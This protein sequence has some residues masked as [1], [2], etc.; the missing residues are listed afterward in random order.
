MI[1]LKSL[2]LKNLLSHKDTTIEFD[3]TFKISLEGASGNGKS[4]IV[5][6]IVWALYGSG[7]ADNRSI[8]RYSEKSASVV[9]FLTKDDVLY[10]IERSINLKGKHELKVFS[11]I[12][13]DH[14]KPI[15]TNGVRE[16]QDHLENEIL[17]SSYELFVN[18]IVYPQDAVDSFI[19]QTAAKRKDILLEIA[20]ASS[21][22]EYYKKTS[23]VISEDSTI[24]TTLE[25]K[26]EYAKDII[27]DNKDSAEK[28][29]DLS[30]EL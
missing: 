1:L 8:I 16:T 10:R 9:L 11:G 26:L 23:E 18:S 24:L 3:E 30:E 7:R 4:A 28:F 12:D 14:L 13:K 6:S 25:T 19:K 27:K 21:Y 15:K 2:Q 5:E 22:D 20:K 17:N 29:K